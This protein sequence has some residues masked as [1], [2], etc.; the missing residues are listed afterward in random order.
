MKANAIMFAN[1]MPKIYDVLPPPLEE[2]DEVLAFIF[3]G[4]CQP[5]PDD[6]KRTPFLVRRQKV[7]EALEWLKLNHCDY[8]DLEI[9]QRNLSEYPENGP[10]V[11]VDYYKSD[12]N[13]DPE[14]AAVNDLV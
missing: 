4:P 5:T 3:T 9:S 8:Y 12:T 1:P 14:S 10:P 6:F 13:K 2:I 11:V 7:S